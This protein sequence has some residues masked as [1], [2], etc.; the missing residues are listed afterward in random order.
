MESKDEEMF[1]DPQRMVLDKG[2][3]IFLAERT[4]ADKWEAVGCCALLSRGGGAFELSK[5]AVAPSCRGLGIGRK[6]LDHIIHHARLVGASRLYIE[7]SHK[8]PNAIH[9]YES[10][11]FTHLPPERI[12][13]SP[14]ER[15]DVYMEML[16]N[17]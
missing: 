15:A 1:A 7:T 6:I 4:A 17:Q 2:G 12:Q 14:Y 3:H 13:P 10:V 9:L 8:L 5:M 16:L 11:G